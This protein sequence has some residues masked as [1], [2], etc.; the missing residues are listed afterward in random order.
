MNEIKIFDNST[1][2]DRTIAEKFRQNALK[3]QSEG[4][5]FSV[6]LCGEKTPYRGIRP[7][8]KIGVPIRKLSGCL[9]THRIEKITMVARS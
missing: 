1:D 2:L 7:V 3:A 9:R 4:R 6:A 8:Y 5:N